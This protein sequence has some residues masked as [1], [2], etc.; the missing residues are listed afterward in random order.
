M[1]R[2]QANAVAWFTQVVRLVTPREW[3]SATTIWSSA[4][5]PWMTI[6]SWTS[7]RDMIFNLKIC[8]RCPTCL[9]RILQ[10]CNST[11]STQCFTVLESTLRGLMLCKAAWSSLWNGL[12]Q[13]YSW[14][15]QESGRSSKTGSKKQ[16]SKALGLFNQFQLGQKPTLMPKLW[17]KLKARPTGVSNTI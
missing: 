1:S 10:A 17:S 14:Q 5:G 7:L 8:R 15:S 3:C 12:D 16:D 4:E 11:W 13:H 2:N 9:F 6:F